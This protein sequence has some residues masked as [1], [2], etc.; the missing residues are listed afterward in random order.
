[1]KKFFK[2]CGI[3]ALF[4]LGFGT[5]LTVA[6]CAMGGA[7]KA[8]SVVSDV[9][10][11]K[12]SFGKDGDLLGVEIGG[13][14]SSDMIDFAQEFVNHSYYDIDDFTSIFE[15]GRENY[16]GTVEKFSISADEV[17]NMELNFGACSCVIEESEDDQFWVEGENVDQMQAYVE[18]DTFYLKV[19]KDGKFSVDEL[20]NTKVRLYVPSDLS[21]DKAKIELGAGS[22]K[23]DVLSAKKVELKVAG[24]ELVIKCLDS[25]KVEAKIGAGSMKLDDVM[26]GKIEGDVGAGSLIIA[27]KINNDAKMKCS[28]GSINLKLQNEFDDFDYSI[29]CSAGEI[30]VGDES[31][32]GVSTSK[33]I[34]N[35]ADAD[36]ELKCSA[37]S[38]KVVFE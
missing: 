15:N 28:A 18:G 6:G 13:V 31:F 21:L 27:G 8:A 25:D 30:R 36:M 14:N 33:K 2:V 11:G 37:G 9:T 4:L 29:A 19:K 10:N 24:G 7:E 23:V 22:V 34:D 16:S 35:D 32:S 5:A 17:E 20:K 1:M 26:I 12:V 3:I 38:I